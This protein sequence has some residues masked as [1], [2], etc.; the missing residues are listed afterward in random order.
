VKALLNRVPRW[1][2]V[3]VLMALAVFLA[4]TPACQ[5]DLPAESQLYVPPTMNPDAIADFMAKARVVAEADLAKFNEIE[6]TYMDTPRVYRMPQPAIAGMGVYVKLYREFKSYEVEDILLT[7]SLLYPVA[8]R[9]RFNCDIYSTY[10]RHI[11]NDEEAEQKSLADTEFTV[12]RQGQKRRLYKV[13]AEGKLKDDLPPLPHRDGYYE[14]PAKNPQNVGA[15][16][17]EGFSI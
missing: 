16:P 17:L 5:P 11:L 12:L 6:K 2:P 14:R 13:D 15:N 7:E 1:S 10:P 9:I 3:P 4:A 8:Y